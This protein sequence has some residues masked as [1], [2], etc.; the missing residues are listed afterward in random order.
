MCAIFIHLKFTQTDDDGYNSNPNPNSNDEY[1]NEGAPVQGRGQGQ[2]G[3]GGGGGGN[4]DP[5]EVYFDHDFKPL[6]GP[7]PVERI[8]PRTFFE[9]FRG[10]LTKIALKTVQLSLDLFLK[11]FG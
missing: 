10:F 9:D 5:D 7:A 6:G 11:R 2:R 8:K 1:P 3:G 4:D